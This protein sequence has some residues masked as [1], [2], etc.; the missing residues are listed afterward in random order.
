MKEGGMCMKETEQKSFKFALL[1][2][3]FLGG[4]GGHRIYVTNHISVILWYWFACFLTFG[5]I[6]II[7]LAFLY[8]WTHNKK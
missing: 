2:W 5:F 8:K 1:I 4:I 3:L 7:D 6:W